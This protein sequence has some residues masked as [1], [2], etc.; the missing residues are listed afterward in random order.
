MDSEKFCE[1]NN[2]IAVLPIK[3]KTYIDFCFICHVNFSEMCVR[4]M[5]I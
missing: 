1:D 3:F 5:G 2:K 4:K